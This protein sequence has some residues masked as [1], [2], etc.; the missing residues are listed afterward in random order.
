MCIWIGD[1]DEKKNHSKVEEWLKDGKDHRVL[2]AQRTNQTV[3]KVKIK[4][5]ILKA[6]LKPYILS[7]RLIFTK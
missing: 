1:N 7:N 3:W 4:P 2:Y 6:N 5:V